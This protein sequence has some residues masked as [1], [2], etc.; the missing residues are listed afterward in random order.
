[1]ETRLLDKIYFLLVEV[2]GQPVSKKFDLDKNVKLVHGIMLS[3]D[4]P[5][6]LYYRGT[7][8]IELSGDEL[9]VEDFESKIL[10]SG[11]SV[12]PKDR[13]WPLGNGVV[14]G[15]GELK[16]L[17]KDTGNSNALFSPYK[18]IIYAQCEM[19]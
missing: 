3:S 13:Y 19:K 11:L 10:M 15:N 12:P 8:R 1:M 4:R 17:Y 18:V 16:I 5:N 14:A 2:E 9:M 7:Q 6:L